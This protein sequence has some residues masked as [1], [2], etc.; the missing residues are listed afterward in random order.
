[1]AKTLA[2]QAMIKAGF[3]FDIFCRVVDNYGDIG[4]CWRLAK[5]L[6]D[7]PH[8]GPVRLWVDDLASFA[9]IE[10]SIDTGASRQILRN[11]ELVHWTSST[12][13]V[14]P[15]D[16]VIEAFGCVPPAPFIERMHDRQS[17]WI[18]LEYLSAEEWIEGCHGLPSLQANGLQKHFFFPGF[19]ETTGGLLR[20]PA[21]AAD[22]TQ[23]LAHAESRLRLLRSLGMPEKLLERLAAGWRQVFLFCYGHAPAQALAQALTHSDRP[24]VVIVPQGVLPDMTALQSDKLQVFES[25]FVDQDDFDRLLWSSDLNIVRGEDSLLRAVWAEKPFVWHIYPQEHDTHMVKL[26]AWLEQARLGAITQSVFQNWNTGDMAGTEQSL[27]QAL[28]PE[29]WSAWRCDTASLARRLAAQTSLTE[30]LLAFC[31]EKADTG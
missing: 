1:M 4:V 15:H 28:Q 21:L 26:G 8:S 25:P 11:I 30:R 18:N 6:A 9:R 3:G 17:L 7:H 10:Q 31:A 19:T 14:L 12:P 22:R 24:S 5:Q 2:R 27:R 20:E 16:V 13:N 29:A 23:W